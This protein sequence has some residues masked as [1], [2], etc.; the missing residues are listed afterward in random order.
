MLVTEPRT[1]LLCTMFKSAV[2]FVAVLVASA[3]AGTVLWDGTLDAAFTSASFDKCGYIISLNLKIRTDND[4]RV[5]GQPSWALSVVH[6][7]PVCDL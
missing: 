6:P 4:C 1:S 7:R 3:Q 2:A 5:L